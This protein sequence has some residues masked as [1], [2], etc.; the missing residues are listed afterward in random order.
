MTPLGP[1]ARLPLAM[2][3]SLALAALVFATLL[4]ALEALAASR[5][6]EAEVPDTPDRWARVYRDA[7]V[8]DQALVLVGSSRTALGID[9]EVLAHEMER[10]VMN[11]AINGGNPLPVLERLADDGFSGRVVVELMEIRFFS[12][13]GAA[14]QTTQDYVEALDSPSLAR[15]LEHRLAT[16]TGSSFRSRSRPF[17]LIELIRV[18]TR[19]GLPQPVQRTL[20]ADRFEVTR[21]DGVDFSTQQT[22]WEMR[23]RTTDPDPDP[24]RRKRLAQV[25]QWVKDIETAGGRVLFVRLPSTGSVATAEDERFPR[26]QFFELAANTFRHSWHYRDHRATARLRCFDGSHLDPRDVST[27][28]RSIGTWLKTELADP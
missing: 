24:V 3:M 15:G 9:P 18:V 12:E 21:I 10:P 28:T 6:V 16:W 2:P 20:R 23:I 13:D 14:K 8:M 25:R 19:G 5:G 4:G 7:L 1:S 17:Q 22:R 11:L 27:L 26:A